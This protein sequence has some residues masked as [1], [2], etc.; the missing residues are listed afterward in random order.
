MFT[1]SKITLAVYAGVRNVCNYLNGLV[2]FN[3]T[4]KVLIC[5]HWRVNQC[6]TSQQDV[7]SCTP[8]FG[9]CLAWF[10]TWTEEQETNVMC[11][12]LLSIRMKCEYIKIF[13]VKPILPGLK[14]PN[15]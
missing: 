2:D 1:A 12:L 15:T 14:E 4:V 6:E 3:C 7:Y 8:L 9:I 11:V 10:M 5:I 13:T